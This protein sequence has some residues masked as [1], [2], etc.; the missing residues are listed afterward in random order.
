MICKNRANSIL[1]ALDIHPKYNNGEVL[2]K[3]HLNE[4][5]GTRVGIIPSNEIVGIYLLTYCN[6]ALCNYT[7]SIN[8]NFKPT[9]E[10]SER[11]NKIETSLLLKKKPEIIID[12]NNTNGEINN[13][14]NTQNGDSFF[15]FDEYHS[16]EIDDDDDDQDVQLINLLE[17]DNTKYSSGFLKYVSRL[18]K[19]YVYKNISDRIKLLENSLF[20]FRKI[21]DKKVIGYC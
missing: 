6:N 5:E 10:S 12:N 14:D 19:L 4:D 13:L 21:E 3:T 16:I 18:G 9:I 2:G 11:K 1:R 17:S 15:V 8:P 20:I 7:Y